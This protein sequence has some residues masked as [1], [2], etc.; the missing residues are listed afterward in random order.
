MRVL[1]SPSDLRKYPDCPKSVPFELL[2]EEQAMKNH[3]QTLDRLNERGGMS[4]IEIVANVLKKDC[5]WILLYDNT[6]QAI[7]VINSW[8]K[9]EE[10]IK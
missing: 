4:P 10:P 7:K 2:N 3:S 8:L 1:L 9:K 6:D 5:L